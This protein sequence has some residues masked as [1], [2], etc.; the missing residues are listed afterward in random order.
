MGVASS[1]RVIRFAPLCRWFKSDWLLVRDDELG[2]V[3][4]KCL[5]GGVR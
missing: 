2:I 1:K 3:E 5:G 4:G